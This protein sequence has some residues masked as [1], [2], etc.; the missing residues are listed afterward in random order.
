MVH[1]VFVFR[2]IMS[3]GIVRTRFTLDAVVGRAH[4]SIDLDTGERVVI[5]VLPD[6]AS[7]VVMKGAS[8]TMISTSSPDA[9]S[10]AIIDAFVYL[11][12][13]I[14]VPNVIMNTYPDLKGWLPSVFKTY[15]LLDKVMSRIEKLLSSSGGKTPPPEIIIFPGIK[16]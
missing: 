10:N 14:M 16:A 12:P 13:A 1:P 9:I 7:V 2:K 3:T 15:P 8:A 5:G 11:V 6:T 4:A